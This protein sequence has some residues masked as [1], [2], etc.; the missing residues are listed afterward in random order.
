MNTNGTHRNQRI[1]T[2]TRTVIAAH[3]KHKKE[4]KQKKGNSTQR[5]KSS[6]GSM[7][8]WEE[9]LQQVHSLPAVRVLQED[10]GSFLTVRCPRCRS[11]Y[12]VPPPTPV[13]V[14]AFLRRAA[15]LQNALSQTPVEEVAFRERVMRRIFQHLREQQTT[16]SEEE[17]E[18][19]SRS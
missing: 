4:R 9:R 7:Q 2:A 16:P 3:E 19:V 10:Q 6:Q 1:Q 14:L 15:A 17:E 5:P 13:P 12:L 18:G 8:S 11:R